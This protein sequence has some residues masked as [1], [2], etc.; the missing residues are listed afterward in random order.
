MVGYPIRNGLVESWEDVERVLRYTFSKK[1]LC[2]P[3]KAK[4]VILTE[5][6]GNPKDNREK[7]VTFMFEELQVK[8]VKIALDAH[9]D[10][11]ASGRTTGLICNFG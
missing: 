8:N 1:L 4:G 6:P 2:E 10:L 9:M 3:E 7:M 11:Y 5:Y